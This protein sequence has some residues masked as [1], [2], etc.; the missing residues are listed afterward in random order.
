MIG[1]TATALTVGMAGCGSSN[2]DV[3][4]KPTDSNCG[5]WEWDDDDG[6]WECDDDTSSYYGH[7]YHGGYYYGNRSLLLNNKAYKSYK[8]SSSFKGG[9]KA[10]S[11]F[12]SGTKTSGG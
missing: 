4:P 6:A 10:S 8:N 9:V 3:P 2:A 12:G 5:D 7:Y 11:G 1:V